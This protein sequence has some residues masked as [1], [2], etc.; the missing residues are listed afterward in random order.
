M[1]VYSTSK[2]GVR[3][4]CRVERC[5]LDL[6][7]VP[8]GSSYRMQFAVDFRVICITARSPRSCRG[9]TSLFG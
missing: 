4:P 3:I 5:R 2:G 7:V 9:L 8:K 1:F 6:G